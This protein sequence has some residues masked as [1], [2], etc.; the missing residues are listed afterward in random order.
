LVIG[1]RRWRN[2]SIIGGG[3]AVGT[4][5]PCAG[6][7]GRLGGA[8]AV[9]A[10]ADLSG[11]VDDFASEVVAIVGGDEE[12]EAVEIAGAGEDAGPLGGRDGVDLAVDEIGEG[13]DAPAGA[14]TKKGLGSEVEFKFE[15]GVGGDGNEEQVREEPEEDLCG[16]WEAGA[17]HYLLPVGIDEEVAGGADGADEAG[18]LGI[19]AEFLAEGGDVDVYRAVEDLVVAVADFLEELLAGFDAAAGADEA[20]EEVELDGGE[21][22]GLVME[23]DD[24]GADVHAEGAGE[25]IRGVRSGGG[26][27]GAEG[28]TA[29]D[30]AETG[31]ELAGGE[32]FR[33]V[34]VGADLE[35]DDAV[36]FVTTGGEHEDGDV[37]GFA[38]LFEDLE[39]VHAGEHEVED[40]GMPGWGRGGGGAFDAFWPGVDGGDVVAEGLEVCGDET[41]ELAIVIDQQEAGAGGGHGEKNSKFEARNSK[42]IRK[43]NIESGEIWRGARDFRRF[44]FPM[45]ERFLMGT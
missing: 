20:G 45:D 3:G 2:L 8:G 34:I 17:H 32:G 11:K 10:G 9:E 14:A 42:Q 5:R 37:A 23:G 27:G 29:D 24:A 18:G 13:V 38:D 31:E 4:G 1:A 44:S 12:M 36:G 35:A 21:I 25:E 33:E 30:G 41:A 15:E 16:E 43:S 40:E 39:A 26:L 19:V 7:T 22:Q 28:A 6:R